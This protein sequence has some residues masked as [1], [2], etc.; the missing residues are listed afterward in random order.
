MPYRPYAS[1]LTLSDC[2]LIAWMKNVL[3]GK[4]F[5]DVEEVKQKA[6]AL[7]SINIDK[8]KKCYEQ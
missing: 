3:K 1:N 2:F 6:E 8:F 7:K 4:H 5:V